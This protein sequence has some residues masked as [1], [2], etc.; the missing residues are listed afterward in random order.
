[1]TAV[2]VLGNRMTVA[3]VGDSR[4]YAVFL[5]GRMQILTRDH[6]LVRR[7]EELGQITAEEASNHPQ[8]H[9][10]YRALG[11]GEPVEPDVF[12]SQ[13]P[14]PGYILVCSDGLWGVVP[15][16]DIFRMISTSPNLHQACLNLVEA[17]NAAGGPDNITAILVRM[18]D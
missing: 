17:A 6:S 18:P 14:A 1:M 16:A 4:A 10:L 2:L 13:V 9:V 15:E 8:R 7:L 11:L 5:D 3:H 12:T